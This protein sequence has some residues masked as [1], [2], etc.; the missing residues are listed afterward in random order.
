MFNQFKL[1]C[2]QRHNE[3]DLIGPAFVFDSTVLYF[4]S[5]KGFIDF[6]N[7]V[8][9]LSGALICSNFSM[10]ERRIKREIKEIEEVY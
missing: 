5:A 3:A 4:V 7:F 6:I 8:L 10:E 1:V 9:F 2:Y